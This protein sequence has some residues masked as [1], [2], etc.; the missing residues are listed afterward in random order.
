MV[1]RNVRLFIHQTNRWFADV[2]RDVRP[3]G[4]QAADWLVGHNLLQLYGI[5]HRYVEELV[6]FHDAS[7]GSVIPTTRTRYITSEVV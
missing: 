1:Y 3:K 7:D 5:D 4:K 2:L 6:R